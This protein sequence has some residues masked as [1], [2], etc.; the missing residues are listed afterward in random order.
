[1]KTLRIRMAVLAL[2]VCLSSP[3]WAGVREGESTD[4]WTGWL[5]AMLSRI[6]VALGLA[7]PE[8]PALVYEADG[9]YT[10]NSGICVDPNGRPK[11]CV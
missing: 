8:S 9:T 7:E 11:P 2:L 3:A 5:G 10:P 1:M 4:R 6:E